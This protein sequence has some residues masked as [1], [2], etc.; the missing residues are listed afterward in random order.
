MNVTAPG[1][2]AELYTSLNGSGQAA[3][4][5]DAGSSDR[6]LKLLVAQMR[7][8]DP[9]NPMD[10]AQ[11]TS[12]LAQINTVEGINRLNTSVSSLSGQFVQLQA[13]QGATL[14]GRDVSVAG[15]RLMISGEGRDAVGRGGYELGG[16]A[17]AVRLEVLNAAGRV[18]SSQDLGAQP[19]GRHDFQWSAAAQGAE[20]GLR[21]RVVA[22]R[23]DSSVTAQP[24]M[25]DRVTAVSAGAD[26]LQLTL[27]NS[28][29][30]DYADVRA[31]HSGG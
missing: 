15:D 7:N 13:M 21:F 26:K 9:L 20:S 29:T 24:L 30:V 19:A 11:V 5:D 4:P 8:Q 2:P 16:P 28:G 22:T 12:Q 18:V 17:D 6:F 31:V 1:S 3:A 14:L 23:G 27:Q 25:H 10:N